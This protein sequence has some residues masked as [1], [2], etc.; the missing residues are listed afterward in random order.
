MARR[1]SNNKLPSARPSRSVE[2]RFSECPECVFY[3]AFHTH[4]SCQGCTA[5]EN[6]EERIEELNPGADHFLS[7]KSR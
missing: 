1:R 5:G 4:K 2:P 7:R 3:R 6:F